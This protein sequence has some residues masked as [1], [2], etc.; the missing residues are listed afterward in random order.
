MRVVKDLEGLRTQVFKQ[1]KHPKVGLIPTMGA[2]H[3]GHQTLMDMARKENDLVVVSIFVNPTQFGPNEDFQRYPR[4]YESD[5]QLA[6]ESGVDVIFAPTVEMVYPR[7]STSIRVAEITDRWEGALRPGHFK[8]VC[9]V[10]AKLFHLVDPHR[11]YFGWKDIQQCLVIQRMVEDLNFPVE[12]KF[13]ETYRDPDGLAFSS[14]NIYLDSNE[15]DKAPMIYRTLVRGKQALSE[16]PF[17]QTVKNSAHTE[18]VQGGFAI[19]YWDVVSLKT[20]EPVEFAGDSCA[21]IVAARLGN[22]RLIDNIRL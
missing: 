13:G 10:V 6:A 4:S 3:K 22:T 21:I 14:R 12:L 19:D 1:S 5:L 17:V 16:N 11:A 18:L 2:L 9:T 7:N 8:G 15:R 20:L